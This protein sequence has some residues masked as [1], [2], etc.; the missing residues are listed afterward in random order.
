MRKLVIIGLALPIAAIA[1][2]IALATPGSGI[3]GGPVLAR[4]TLEG[5]FKLK[6]HDSSNTGDVVVQ[7]VLI[8]PGGST[9]W[10]T[11]PVRPSSSSSPASS[12][13]MKATPRSARARSTRPVRSSSIEATATST[14]GGT[15]GRNRSSSTSSTSTFPPR[16]PSG[17]TRRGRPTRPAA[18]RRTDV[19]STILTLG[20]AT[21]ARPS[22]R[23]RPE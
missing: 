18:S 14:S 10:H 7:Q 9:G 2:T 19:R 23:R 21:V 16:E 15:K 11:H 3:L 20:T 6:L 1:A 8:A 17:S 12:P 5:Q 13:S 22:R 4:G